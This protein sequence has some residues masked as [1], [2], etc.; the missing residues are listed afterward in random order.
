MVVLAGFEFPGIDSAKSA[1]VVRQFP[2]QYGYE[3]RGGVHSDRVSKP[4][5]LFIL[6]YFLFRAVLLF[7]N[8]R[9]F[10]SFGI[11][12][13]LLQSFKIHRFHKDLVSYWIWHADAL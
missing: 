13:T 3:L 4:F 8:G 9:L 6:M 1:F 12:C 10:L 2:S 7:Y 5:F 11:F